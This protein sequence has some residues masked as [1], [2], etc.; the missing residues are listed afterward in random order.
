MLRPFLTCLV[1]CLVP[2]LLLALITYW[3]TTSSAESQQVK[4]LQQD[5]SRFS[6]RVDKILAEHDEVLT[7]LAESKALSS[8]VA[9]K[10]EIFPPEL[11]AS[12]AVILNKPTHYQRIICFD[13]NT[14]VRFIAEP[15]RVE[16]NEPA[17]IRVFIPNMP[18]PD[19]RVWNERATAVLYSPV[20]AATTF[21][22]NLLSRVPVFGS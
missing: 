18:Q 12:L 20:T 17:G 11:Q 2:L 9:G 4:T 3:A 16:Q 1:L 7:A 14:Q 10:E 6:Q 15:G 8:Y 22:S 19:E 5:L 13:R 21:G